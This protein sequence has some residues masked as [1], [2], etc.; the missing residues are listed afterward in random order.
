M[1]LKYL[2]DE[3]FL[4]SNKYLLIKSIGSLILLILPISLHFFFFLIVL[5]VA[6]IQIFFIFL[7]LFIEIS[8]SLFLYLSAFLGKLHWGT[9]L[10]TCCIPF[11]LGL[12]YILLNSIIKEK[13][14]DNSKYTKLSIVRIFANKLETKKLYSAYLLLITTAAHSI[15]GILWKQFEINIYFILGV[16]IY[17]SL[18]Y[19]NTL[20]VN[21][22]IKKGFYG[23]NEFEAREII[24]F[25]EENSD[26]IDFSDGDSPKKLFNEEDLKEIEQEIRLELNNGLPQPNI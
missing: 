7:F 11:P 8:I 15:L 6:K 3:F 13:D 25:I 20:L 1:K 12:T 17:A 26:T 24:N 14:F 5:L 22:R 18:L 4:D 21:F 16:S 9:V 19:L 23:G 2:F 10:T